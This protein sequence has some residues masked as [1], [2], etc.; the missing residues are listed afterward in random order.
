MNLS[1]QQPKT[2][3][4]SKS[5]SKNL[6]FSA[7]LALFLATLG[8]RAASVGAGG[9]TNAFPSQPAAIDFAGGSIAG[10][11]G[12][13]ADAAGMDAAVATVTAASVNAQ[14]TLLAGSPPGAAAAGVYNDTDKNLQLRPTGS[15]TTLI[16]ATFTNNSGA[17][18]TS[19]RLIYSLIQST[20]LAEQVEGVRVYYSLTGAASSWT[21]VPTWSAAA[22]GQVNAEVALSGPWNINSPLYLLFADDNGSPSPDTA[23]QIDNF[24]I[25]VANGPLAI[26]SQPQSRTNNAGTATSFTVEV[27]GAAPYFFNW[28][29]GATPISGATNQTYTIPVVV[30]NDAANYFVIVSNLSTRLTSSVAALTVTIITPSVSITAP[31]N[32]QAF[33]FGSNL[34]ISAN[35]NAGALTNVGFFVDGVLIGNDTNSPYSL[36]YSNASVGSHALTAVAQDNIGQRATSAV[37][38]ITVSLPVPTVAIT[39]PTNTQSFSAGTSITINANATGSLTNVGF[40]ADNVL[41]GNDTNSP[42]SLVYS[43]ASAGGHALTAVARDSFGQ[44]VTSA[45]VN[46]TVALVAPTVVITAPTNTQIFSYGSNLTISASASAGVITNVGFFVDGVLIGN[47]VSNPYSLG[48]SNAAVGG[49]ALTAVVQDNL[50]QRVT[51]SVVNITITLPVPTVV[52][53][54]PTNTQSVIAG[55]NLTIN[56]NTTA[57]IVTNVAFFADGVLIGNDNS[58]PYSFVYPAVPNGAHALTAVVQD[59]RGQRAT[60]AVVNITASLVVP[61]VAVTAPVN[62]QSFL[63][64]LDIT[65]NASVTG[66]VLTNVSFYRDGGELIGNDPSSPFGM[67][68]SGATLGV[69]SLTAVVRDNLGQSATSAV[70]NITVM[71]GPGIS[72]V[73]AGAGPF[74]FGAL[75]TVAD[76]WSTTNFPGGSGDVVNTV[77]MDAAIQTVVATGV[78]AALPTDAALPVSAFNLF[79]WNSAGSF[80]ESRANN[81]KL[82]LL[83]ATLRN[84]VGADV[85]SFTVSYNLGELAGNPAESLPGFQAYYSLSGALGTWQLIPALSTGTTGAL[86]ATIPVGNWP[87]NS[88]M[89]LLWG[90]DN[91]SGTEG[92]YTIDNFAIT[93][94]VTNTSAPVTITSQP[95]NL[96]REVGQSAVFTVGVSGSSP[97]FYAWYFGANPIGGANGP[98]YTIPSVSAGNA[99]QYRVVVSNSFSS[100]I[101]SNALLTVT[102]FPVVITNQPVGA[103]VALGGSATFNVGVSGTPPYF[104]RWFFGGSPI[105]NATNSSYTV[106]NAQSANGGI[107][108]VQV[109]NLNSTVISSNANLVVI[110]G[111]YTLVAY[112]NVWQ[113]NQSNVDLGTAWKEVA[114]N[115]SSWLSGP[116]ILGVEG[117]ALPDTLRTPLTLTFPGQGSGT[118]TYYFRTRVVLSDSPTAVTFA[119]TNVID[120]GAVFYVNG[121]EVGQFGMPIGV[122]T[123]TTLAAATV[124][125]AV[126]VGTTFPSG[127]WI[128]GTN[129][130][131]VEVHQSA[132]GSS[133]IVF[134]MQITATVVPSTLLTITNQPAS[135]T[136]EETKPASF[137]VGVSGVG[138]QFQWFKNGTPIAGADAATYTIPVSNTNDTGTYSVMASNLVNTVFSSNAILVVILDTNGPTLVKADGSAGPSSVLVSFSELISVGSAN[139][140]E[141][142][143]IRSTLGAV[144]PIYTATLQNGTNVQLVTGARVDG[145]NH[146]LTVNNIRDVALASNAILTNSAIP[147][148]TILYLAPLA[149]VWDWYQPLPGLDPPPTADWK[150]LS[151]R[152]EDPTNNWAAGPYAGAAAF[153]ADLANEPLPVSR[154]TSMSLGAPDAYFRRVFVYNG[155]PLGASARFRH[156]VDDTAVFYLNNVQ[157]FNFNVGTIGVASLSSFINLPLTSLQYGSNVLAVQLNGGGDADMVFAMEMQVLIN[158]VTNGPVVIAGQPANQTVPIGQSASFAV[159]P[160]AALTVQWQRNGTNLPGATNLTYTVP[161]ATLGMVGDTFRAVATGP[162][163]TATSSNALLNVYV[164]PPTVVMTAPTNTQSFSYGSDVTLSANA[165]GSVSNVSFYSDGVLVGTDTSSPYSL[166]YSNAAPAVHALTAVVQDIIGQK[167][168][169]AVVNITVIVPVP[170]VAITSPAEET[171]FAAV[172]NI[173]INASATGGVL[174]NVAFFVDGALIGNDPASPYSFVYPSAPAGIHA[175][176][177]VVQDN[178]GQRATSGVVTITV[179]SVALP[180]LQ[181]TRSGGGVVTLTWTGSGYTLQRTAALLGTNTPW[182]DAPGPVTTSPFTTNNPSGNAF[183]RLRQ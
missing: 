67:V 74:G 53:T 103:G 88:V 38:S 153:V 63:Q 36:V 82:N 15:K 93:T 84:N 73:V 179:T 59:D 81:S 40:Y 89:Y 65:I 107:Y 55:T 10:G 133:D 49:H 151:F 161:V 92:S 138:A 114:Y 80:I 126:A 121:V 110:P 119:V 2:D 116:G 14:L 56:A 101:S 156:V 16:M 157:V 118:L 90:D 66:G 91:A 106:N 61:T 20:I 68:Y 164:L 111:P 96:V 86:T 43:N 44:S 51:S 50:G 79:R 60:S 102:N 178:Q 83:M 18:A 47:D 34:T 109:S 181:I 21:Y 77:Q 165:S 94:V 127:P 7:C 85:G 152:P 155:S 163:G 183:F 11:S 41:I 76:G 168:T 4:H 142:Y 71:S 167:A 25:A 8:A 130:L 105:A 29:K 120:D 72:V 24:Y 19:V 27:S 70:V 131:A 69:H 5:F 124:G 1:V 123:H 128:K 26:T 145:V 33:F 48:Y 6:L 28:H 172:N 135:L 140:V 3:M 30:T 32:T 99:G 46:I 54:A 137:T 171:A 149:G 148:S 95:P 78:V 58:S 108:S 144:V 52:I 150:Q 98:T 35:A 170:T 13:V 132:A 129:V 180:A 9:Y 136:V 169:S 104:Y 173:T 97:Y 62:A 12:D 57:G 87:A 166:V 23:N 42:Y 75:P 147:V 113:Y 125:D 39:A 175:L 154:G 177:A 158:S 162:G 117:A 45:V 143:D 141:N 31:T 122:F 37:V 176:T 139:D 17:N 146:I 22:A 64:G 174:T 100:A 160:V 112:S 159:S 182:A 134:G 115:D